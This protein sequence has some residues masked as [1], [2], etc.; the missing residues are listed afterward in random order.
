MPQHHL[1]CVLPMRPPCS[2]N[3][4]ASP[5]LP[6]KASGLTG[7]H[8]RAMSLCAHGRGVCPRAAGL[9]ERCGDAA[10]L[11]HE[12]PITIEP[13]N[14][15]VRSA[16]KPSPRATTLEARGGVGAS[17]SGWRGIRRIRQSCDSD[18]IGGGSTPAP[19]TMARPAAAAEPSKT[20]DF[21]KR[22]PIA[23]RG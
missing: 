6:G 5:P 15:R 20:N 23:Q 7:W 3:G 19:R 16:A 13:K 8:V 12:T 22:R 21:D 18:H 1:V 14:E 2:R 4:C 9:A 17:N 10:V 11:R